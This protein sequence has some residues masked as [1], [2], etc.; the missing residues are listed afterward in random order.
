MSLASTA[1]VKSGRLLLIVCYVA[2]WSTVPRVW[3]DVSWL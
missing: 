3:T 2:I 1:E